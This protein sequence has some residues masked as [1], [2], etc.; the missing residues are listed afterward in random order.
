ML[1]CFV[2]ALSILLGAELNAELE[3]QTSRD[4]TVG[5]ALPAGERGAFVADNLGDCR[6]QLGEMVRARLSRT[7]QLAE[8][9][10]QQ[11]QQQ[12]ARVRDRIS[13]VE[14]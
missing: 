9:A 8:R 11:A 3:H 13:K 14:E 7:R 6:P 4:T 5:P 1:W 12:A 10:K 2:T